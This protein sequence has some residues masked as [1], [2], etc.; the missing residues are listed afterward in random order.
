MNHQPVYD[1]SIKRT[2]LSIAVIA[3]FMTPFMG[4][5]INVALPSIGKEFTADAVQLSWVAT[6]YILA[7]AI[8]LVPLGKLA[9]I[10]GRKKIYTTGLFTFILS[11]PSAFFPLQS[12]S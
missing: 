1:R 5:A 11:T 2:A 7:A 6:S 8:F 3:S 9:D 4:S 10:V 12:T